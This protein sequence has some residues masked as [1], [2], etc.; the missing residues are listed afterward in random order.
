MNSSSIKNIFLLLFFL[1]VSCEKS[2]IYVTEKG[3]PDYFIAS[4]Q[5]SS[6]EL[7]TKVYSYGTDDIFWNANDLIS[8][9]GSPAN[10]QYRFIGNTGDNVGKFLKNGDLEL[11]LGQ[12]FSCYYAVFP[13]SEST[14]SA[15]EGTIQF[16]VPS[17][18]SYQ[19]NAIPGGGFLMIATT[20][21]LNDNLIKF[22]NAYGYLKLQIY[23][24]SHSDIKQ[25]NISG[26]NNEP[27]YGAAIIQVSQE[28]IP[29]I[30]FPSEP[31]FM[32]T[33]DCG[34]GV[35]FGTESS[36]T[37][38]YI[39]LPPTHFSKGFTVEVINQD[40]ESCTKS[41]SKEIEIKRSS[42]LS[43]E[44]ADFSTE[45]RPIIGI[46][47][48]TSE[49][50]VNIK[51]CLA[52]AGAVMYVMPEYATSSTI[53][54]QY[55]E[56]IDGLIIPGSGPSDPGLRNACDIRL[57]KAAEEKGIPVLGICQGHQN[58][59]SA[60]GGTVSHITDLYPQAESHKY[61]VGN[62]NY[63]LY[64]KHHQIDIDSN[65]RLYSILE[66][67][68]SLWV[69]TS[70]IDCVK[71]ENVGTG[72]KISALSHNDGIV[73]ALESADGMVIGVQY[74]PE[75]MYAVMNDALSLNIF[76]DLVEKAEFIKQTNN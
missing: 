34:E 22:R 46:G 42:L 50:V 76:K 65:S 6:G 8:I 21:N 72:L 48:S 75:V 1:A 64:E 35:K 54:E 74:H 44:V 60:F 52:D 43:M 38:F 20:D 69:N 10:E 39:A 16:N 40:N 66:N 47:K 49:Q 28:G 19:G 32:I 67:N 68:G 57:I 51:K 24:F 12:K 13:Y 15:T 45:K 58:I 73:E 7:G 70:H 71:S 59:S 26:N 61:K 37:E 29:S 18:Q 17:I 9:F 56:M 3:S 41:T 11:I 33:L 30:S 55:I 25:V 31:G 63:W 53:A 14:A 5:D 62:T 23:G 27:L 36:P 4:M 2:G